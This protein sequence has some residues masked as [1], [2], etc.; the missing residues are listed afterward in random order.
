[1]AQICSHSSEKAE[2]EDDEWETSLGCAVNSHQLEY[3]VR[4]YCKAQQKF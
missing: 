3:L 1:M 2:T 4:S